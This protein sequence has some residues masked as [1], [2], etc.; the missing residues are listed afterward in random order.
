M[1]S[2]PFPRSLE[3]AVMQG[4]VRGS[5]VRDSRPFGGRHER[6]CLFPAQEVLPQRGHG[7]RPHHG[8]AAQI[9]VVEISEPRA[10]LGPVG[11]KRSDSVQIQ[12]GNRLV[13]MPWRTSQELRGRL[14]ASGLDS[15][16]D[17]FAA[18]GT[19]APVVVDVTD[20]EPLLALVTAW[21]EAVGERRAV[22]R[23]GLL[24]L[25]DALRDDLESPPP[26]LAGV[27]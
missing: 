26:D 6:V 24:D 16:E 25:R 19:S 2:A 22:A 13:E 7:L 12:A 17:E 9:N 11:A 14:L 20:K 18:K 27:N 10:R 3:Q 21:I 4:K 1:A 23:G 5:V 15:L 8:T